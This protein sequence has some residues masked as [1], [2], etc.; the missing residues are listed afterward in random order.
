[1]AGNEVASLV[2]R[3][4]VDTQDALRLLSQFDSSMAQTAKSAETHSGGISGAFKSMA[5]NA[6][7]FGLG[8]AGFNGISAIFDGAKSAI[9]GFNSSMEQSQIAFTTLLGSSDAAKEHLDDLLNF[10]KTTPFEQQPLIEMDQK[11]E[12]MGISADKVI[13]TLTAVGDAVAG[14][15]G[16]AQVMDRVTTAIGQM[17]AKGKA[18]S[19]EMMQLTEAGI[20]A[21]QMLADKIGVTVPQAMDMVT[22]GTISSGQAIDALTQGME[23]RF[24]G[25]MAAQS[26]TFSGA[27][28]TISDSAKIALGTAFEPL[29]SA[30]S[31][32]AVQMAAFLSSDKFAA[33]SANVTAAITGVIDMIGS[34]VKAFQ[35]GDFGPFLDKL[36]AVGDQIGAAVKEWGSKLLSWIGDN[37]GPATEALGQ[38]G[39][40]VVT[41]IKEDGVPMLGRALASWGD[42]F[43]DWLGPRIGPMLQATG[44][45]LGGILEWIGTTALPQIASGLA[46]WGETFVTWIGPRIGPMLAELGGLLTQLGGWLVGTALPEIV[47]HLAEWGAEFTAWVG[48]QIPPMLAALGGLLADLGGWLVGTA[49]PEIVSHLAEWG[50]SFVSWVAPKI[51][52]L[53]G[54]LGGLLGSL[55][56]WVVGTALPAIISN[57]AQW[58]GAFISWIATDV[59]PKLPGALGGI[60]SSIAGWITGTALP[61]ALGAMVSVGEDL[62]RGII[63]GIG[64]LAGEAA[65]AAQRVVQGAID[66]AKKLLHIG[67]P[68]KLAATEIGEPISQGI[69]IGILDAGPLVAAAITSVVTA[70]IDSGISTG[71]GSPFKG[72]AGALTGANPNDPSGSG[73]GGGE[74]GGPTTGP[75]AGYPGWSLVKVDEGGLPTYKYV[76]NPADDHTPNKDGSRLNPRNAGAIPGMPG[77]AHGSG[78]PLAET[79]LAIV[80]RGERVLNPAETRAYQEQ[81]PLRAP[82]GSSATGFGG[83]STAPAAITIQ[84]NNPQLLNRAQADELAGTLVDALSRAFGKRAAMNR[85]G[86]IP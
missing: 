65:G 53:L 45:F 61:W 48:P 8:M 35:S 67:S 70:G 56:G 11:L 29:F 47:S 60:I 27:M 23:T 38:F 10:A 6:A 82:A 58:A 86:T 33:W 52:E 36:G 17:S 55:T 41:W 77:F 20:P 21:W 49:L 62:I 14:L 66:G 25:M 71:F 2:A 83:A 68:S 43:I 28:S 50:A 59:L 37:I 34:L 3:L 64:N 46:M 5:G 12:A 84:V 15:G 40:V 1:M 24:G 75:I 51:P 76:Y 73:G 57:V 44:E 63:A 18:S 7:S 9:F 42:A 31:Q 19:E 32:G 81:I 72:I 13:P 78:G 79:T 26:Q 74:G 80:H 54:E 69:A 39:E 4:E 22:K 85:L 16:N 30:V